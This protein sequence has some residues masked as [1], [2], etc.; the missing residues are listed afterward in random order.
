MVSTGH[1]QQGCRVSGRGRAH[2]HLASGLQG[3]VQSLQL[4]AGN[5]LM[6]VDQ[7]PQGVSLDTLL[8]AGGST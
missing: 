8:P 7:E 2:T 3:F 4:G 6:Q 1:N 5:T